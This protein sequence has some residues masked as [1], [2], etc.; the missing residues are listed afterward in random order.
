MTIE[1]SY[2][3]PTAAFRPDSSLDV[4]AEVSCAE[5]SCLSFSRRRRLLAFLAK[6]AAVISTGTFFRSSVLRLCGTVCHELLQ[7]SPICFDFQVGTLN[8]ST[9]RGHFY[10][11]PFLSGI[12]NNVFKLLGDSILD[13]VCSTLTAD[14]C[15]HFADNNHAEL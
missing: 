9:E 2:P 5:I 12:L 7:V 13:P 15:R 1:L 4:Y 6:V 10:L 14:S 11:Q 3:Q 8:G